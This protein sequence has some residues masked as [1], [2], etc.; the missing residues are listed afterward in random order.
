MYAEKVGNIYEVKE[1]TLDAE[2]TPIDPEEEVEETTIGLTE[3][4]ETAETLTE[5][6]ENA[7]L[8]DGVDLEN[9]NVVVVVDVT[10][11]EKDNLE[12][13]VIAKIEELAKKATIANYFDIK[14]L[15]NDAKDNENLGYIP[16]L[17]KE[18]EL[19]VVLPEELVNTDEKVNR[20]YYIIRE[21][22]G[23]VEV[24]EDV[25]VSEDGKSIVFKSDKF[26]TYALAYEDEV[27]EEETPKAPEKTETP[28]N[29]PK[30]SD[31]NLALLIGT[32][33]LGVVGTLLV[34]KKRFAKNH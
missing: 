22:N 14:V 7:E 21:H 9:T 2:V 30:T 26:S 16:E 15:V 8:E 23:E 3:N 29:P 25:T 20:K 18:I 11:V 6:V 5:S 12:E 1:Y 4:E 33:M 10:S 31:I 17:T 19:M 13:D 28:E 27:V 34:S 24:L 32:I